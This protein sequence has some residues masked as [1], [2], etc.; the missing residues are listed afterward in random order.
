MNAYVK[1][2]DKDEA[3]KINCSS[4]LEWT[5]KMVMMMWFCVLL[6]YNTKIL[7]MAVM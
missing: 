5:L 3:D 6:Q 1:E 2:I 4:Y 7:L